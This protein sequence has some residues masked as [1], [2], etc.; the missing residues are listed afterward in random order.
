MAIILKSGQKV[1]DENG[2][3][4]EIESGDVLNESAPTPIEHLQRVTTRPERVYPSNKAYKSYGLRP[5][6]LVGWFA[7]KYNRALGWHIYKASDFDKR[8][9]GND[10][11]RTYSEQTDSTS[12]I[13]FNLLAGTY[14]FIDNEAYEDGR[15]IFDKMTKYD[16]V[17]IEPTQTAYDEFNVF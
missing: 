4:Y 16:R 12:I 10:I 1:L 8:E 17:L 9:F 5:D 11:F 2:N 6:D 13:K 7:N 14:A 3:L 15:I